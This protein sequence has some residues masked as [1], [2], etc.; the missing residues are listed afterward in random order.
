MSNFEMR[1]VRLP[2]WALVLALII[3]V[4]LVLTFA[5]VAAG[6][7]LIVFPVMF[8]IAA[9]AAVAGMLRGRRVARRDL[10]IID[11]DYVVHHERFPRDDQ[12]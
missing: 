6:L 11:A 8:L 2:R 7:F 4:A 12:R 10:R 5:V 9:I 3:V 1:V